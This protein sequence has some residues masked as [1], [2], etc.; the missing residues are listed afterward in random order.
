MR[1]GILIFSP[2]VCNS[3]SGIL[4]LTVTQPAF[5]CI[6][7]N[8]VLHFNLDSLNPLLHAFFLLQG[9]K[10][11]VTNWYNSAIEGYAYSPGGT[12]LLGS[13]VLEGFIGIVARGFTWKQHGDARL[14]SSLLLRGRGKAVGLL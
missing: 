6:N 7:L 10:L 14:A 3:G 8:Q 4:T 1:C 9:V 5:Y 2:L 11:D 13:L 12:P